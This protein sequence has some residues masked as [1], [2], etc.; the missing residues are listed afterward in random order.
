MMPEEKESYGSLPSAQSQKE[1]QLRLA[2]ETK[3]PE[4]ALQLNRLLQGHRGT[5]TLDHAYKLSRFTAFLKMSKRFVDPCP[6]TSAMIRSSMN[7]LRKISRRTLRN[8]I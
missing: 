5:D 7:G 6:K 8:G 3:C 1:H 4:H 2:E